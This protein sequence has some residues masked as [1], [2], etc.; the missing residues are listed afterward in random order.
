M[1]TST[2]PSADSA[3]DSVTAG[4]TGKRVR[5]FSDTPRKKTVT[6][7]KP[8]KDPSVHL[9]ESVDN[10]RLN[11]STS[12]IH[13]LL[14]D[15]STAMRSVLN[16]SSHGDD[17]PHL[18]GSG[19]LSEQPQPHL[20]S[21]AAAASPRLDSSLVSPQP[22]SHHHHHHHFHHHR[23]HLS[24]KAHPK[25]PQSRPKL[26]ANFNIARTS[27]T[28]PALPKSQ[29]GSEIDTNENGNMQ[30]AN[31]NVARTSSTVPA[32]PKSQS[33]GEIESGN[34]PKAGEHNHDQESSKAPHLGVNGY[35]VSG[36]QEEA[37][38]KIQR[39]YRGKKRLKE[40]IS[41]DVKV[42]SED[43][44]KSSV[45][46]VAGREVDVAGE[47]EVQLKHVRDMLEEKKDELNRS[48]LEE[49]E[50]LREE[51]EAKERK[52]LERDQKRAAKMKA[53]REAA[54]KELH[55]K[56]EEKRAKQEEIA[57]EEIVS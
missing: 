50:R 24:S 15:I 30:A 19:P 28:L 45:T 37:A 29:S 56:R 5:P 39:W 4:G 9:R 53:D 17:S 32:L 52:Q 33:A 38:V 18:S 43:A 44:I 41:E 46:S 42:I 21:N 57:L 20:K 40:A 51:A 47:H 34:M 55:R 3:Q 6:Q 2:R 12:D 16:V 1:S 8:P 26:A 25:K 35:V 27:S 14:L 48:R 23:L 22:D 10:D 36:G 13:Q 11:G 7:K 49:V 54:I 31:F